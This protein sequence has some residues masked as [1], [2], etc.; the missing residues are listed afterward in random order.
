MKI[1]RSDSERAIKQ[2]ASFV[3]F[4]IALILFASV[5]ISALGSDNREDVYIFGYKPFIVASASME[6]EYKTNSFVLIKRVN[7][8]SIAVGQTVAFRS[9]IMSD[10]VVFHRVVDVTEAGLVTKGDSNDHEDSVAVTKDRFIGREVYHT[11]VLA[12]FI[13]K[14]KSS[15]D[16]ARY[17]LVSGLVV[18]VAIIIIIFVIRWM[19]T[20]RRV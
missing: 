20:M 18:L 12:G 14:L 17:G 4:G 5:A 11:N 6:P 8:D 15:N 2:I 1:E 13:T 10:N 3:F 9:E 19:S 7:M 16:M